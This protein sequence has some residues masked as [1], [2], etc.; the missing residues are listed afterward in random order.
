MTKE[1]KIIKQYEP[2]MHKLLQ[3]VPTGN[4]YED[5]MQELRIVAWKVFKKFDKTR[6]VKLDTVIYK[7][8]KYR[9]F[10]LLQKG[11]K[12]TRK[13]I[14]KGCPD[15]KQCN[16]NC[17]KKKWLLSQLQMRRNAQ[18]P[19]QYDDFSRT[20]RADCLKTSNTAN[21]IK[22]NFLIEQINSQL[23]SIDQKI[24]KGRISGDTQ[25]QLAKKLHFSQQRI[26]QRI[27][28]IQKIVKEILRRR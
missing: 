10:Q 16:Q 2:L 21:E 19:L 6:N 23:S 17:S 28:K 4:N 3:G 20:K 12:I 15:Y 8:F 24:F 27:K 11:A 1:D 22:Y 26:S 25:A 9:I 5:Y 18:Q 13:N 14:C 7:S